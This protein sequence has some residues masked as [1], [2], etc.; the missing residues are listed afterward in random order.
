MLV[1]MY[2]HHGASAGSQQSG[3]PWV[4]ATSLLWILMMTTKEIKVYQEKAPYANRILEDREVKNEGEVKFHLAS[5]FG[6]S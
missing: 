6:D 2:G 5:A 3:K 4:V 1:E